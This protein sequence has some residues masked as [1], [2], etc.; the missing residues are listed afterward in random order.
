MSNRAEDPGKP[1]RT[2]AEDPDLLRAM[3]DAIP[4]RVA[5]IDHEHRYIHVNREF[6]RFVEMSASQVIGHTI[7]EVLGQAAYDR[8]LPLI[9]SASRG[10]VAQWEGWLSGP[11]G[12]RFIQQVFTPYRTGTGRLNILAFTRDL[13]SVKEQEEELRARLDALQAAEAMNTAIVA[14]ALDC[15]IV[16]D[17][18]GRVVEFNPAAEA[19]FGYR[20][21]DTIGRPVRDLI[22]PPAMRDRHTAGMA[23]YIASGDP[24]LLGR[25]I[26]VQ[27][28]RADGTTIPIELTLTEVRLPSRRLFTA[29]LRDLTAAKE[30]ETELQ[31]QR[32]RLHQVEKLSA[33][34]S[35]LAG[36]AHELNNPLAILLAQATLLRDKAQNDDLK[37]RA[38]R[39]YAAAERSGRIVKSFLALARQKPP[40]REEVD[41]N[42]V[43][44][45][46]IEMLGYGLRSNGIEVELSGEA[47]L[48]PVDADRD[49]LGQVVANLL[50]NAQQVLLDRPDPRRVWI[51]T[52][53][54]V[55]GVAL[56]VADNGPGVAAELGD[57]IF[58][59]FFTTKPVGV[60][61]GIG[62]SICR[63]I[64]KAHGGKL[65]LGM[66][67]SG[68]ASFRVVLPA[69]A[70]ESRETGG[71]APDEGRAGQLRILVVDDEPDVA[72]SLAEILERLGHEVLVADHGEGGLD[73]I[74]RARID[75]VFADLRMP[76]MTGMSL[77]DRIRNQHPGLADRVVL[78]TGDTVNGGDAIR[79]RPGELEPVLLEKPFT[80]AEVEACLLAASERGRPVS[81]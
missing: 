18:E 28:A 63:N 10:E 77:R 35:L 21:E 73:A 22:V 67:A 33:M 13:T 26:E 27:G 20:R 41:L 14:F 42:A 79:A 25:R 60:G 51:R 17:E 76:G 80:R 2:V 66:H 61:T 37:R 31:S 69:A 64:V 65:E 44:A 81:G 8:L 54:L 48:P 45:G 78:M 32:E 53:R 70:H 52:E 15:V 39:I 3:M 30:A 9:V 12:R 7:G 6:L 46:A 16:T 40:R 1:A 47:D 5:A 49:L 36:V 72:L 23:R 58:E 19:T 24:K 50:I 75:V 74:E 4:A 57:R 55:S 29:H 71:R 11:A 34:G 68:G 59:P 38:E 43:A 62:L 56:E